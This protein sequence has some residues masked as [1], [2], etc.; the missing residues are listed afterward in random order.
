VGL[1][2]GDFEKAT[3]YWRDFAAKQKLKDETNNSL[4]GNE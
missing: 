2:A 1:R 4:D 3:V